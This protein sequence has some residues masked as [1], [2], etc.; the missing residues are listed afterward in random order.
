MQ[1]TSDDVND[2]IIIGVSDSEHNHEVE[3]ADI[4]V[5]QIKE[6]IFY[7]HRASQKN[8]F[9]YNNLFTF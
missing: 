8:N 4:K 1:T 7:L 5:L 9:F 2:S 6:N 3:S